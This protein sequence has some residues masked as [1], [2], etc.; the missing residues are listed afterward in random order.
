MQSIRIFPK[1]WS[2]NPGGDLIDDDKPAAE[3]VDE[4]T[5]VALEYQC[6]QCGSDFSTKDNMRDHQR[7]VHSG[8]EFLL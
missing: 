5:D 6:D 4:V 7:P 1:S 8:R 2:L 3:D